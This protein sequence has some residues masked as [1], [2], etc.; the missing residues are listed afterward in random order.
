[1]Q[2]PS[3]SPLART[4]GLDSGL[5]VGLRL[6]RPRDA[7]ALAP[8]VGGA[9]RASD[10]LTFDPARRIVLCATA[11]LDGA[12]AVV[13]VGAI[14]RHRGAD[15]DLVAVDERRA[16]GLDALLGSVLRARAN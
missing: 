2:P 12:E 14:A 13:G 16:R 9:E 11:P 7:P 15:P 5:R 3:H 4:H 6:A 10:L 1:M 8:L